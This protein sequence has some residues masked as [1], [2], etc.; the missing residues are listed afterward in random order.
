[1]HFSFIGGN[2]NEVALQ[3]FFLIFVTSCNFHGV[4][5]LYK[6]GW[7][8]SLH[9]KTKTVPMQANQL[10]GIATDTQEYAPLTNIGN[11]RP[12]V[13]TMEVSTTATIT[14]L[15]SKNEPRPNYIIMLFSQPYTQLT[16]LPS[17]VQQAVTN[18]LGVAYFHLNHLENTHLY[19]TYYVAAFIPMAGGYCCKSIAPTVLHIKKGHSATVEVL[20]E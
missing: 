5:F 2:E 12:T 20:V 13:A 10:F 8:L 15:T 4:C 16:T 14:A 9:K 3:R 17:I 18:Q 6:H 11:T 7:F 1:M 19:T